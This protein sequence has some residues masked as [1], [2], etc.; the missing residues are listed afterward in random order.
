MRVRPHGRVLHAG[1]G[2]PYAEEESDGVD[3]DAPLAADDLLAR[4]DALPG[5]EDVGGG[6]DA[7]GADDAGG[8]FV[9]PAF[10]PAD[11]AAEEAVELVEYAFFLPASEV[12]VDGVPVG[13]VVRQIAPGDPGAVHIEDR[14]QQASQVVI[15]WPAD[16]QPAAS[17]LC[18]P[19][20]QDR[21]HQIPSG[22][23]EAAWIATTLSHDSGVPADCGP[24]PGA[25]IRRAKRTV[26]DSA[27]WDETG[28]VRARLR[29]QSPTSTT[30]TSRST[31]LIK[32]ESHSI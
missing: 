13:V 5:G 3:D 29:H 30:G 17:A 2:D 15:R 14:V 12:S 8:W 19:C 27:S 4:V 22:I 6:L 9:V 24:G 28:G 32:A 7:L 23:G 16:V 11:L 20:G 31:H 25:C 18:P 21:L 1:R 26:H 10:L